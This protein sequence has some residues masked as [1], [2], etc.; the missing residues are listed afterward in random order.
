[1]FGVGIE[2]DNVFES[3][4]LTNEMSWLGYSIIYNEIVWYKQSDICSETCEDLLLECFPG[5]FTQWMADN[6]DHNL[7]S[8][9]SLGTVRG[10]K[11]ITI[12]SPKDAVPLKA[13]SHVIQR[14]LR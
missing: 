11:I 2:M 7:A 3:K 1:M 6:V 8:L 10:M 9:D 12:S 5:T 4:R 14:L 13:R